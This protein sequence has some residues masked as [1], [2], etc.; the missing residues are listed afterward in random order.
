MQF[1]A[2]RK[3]EGGVGG[4]QQ[5]PAVRLAPDLRRTLE[6]AAAS[7]FGVVV[8]VAAV[9]IVRH[10]V[11]AER[12]LEDFAGRRITV[13]QGVGAVVCDAIQRDL[14]GGGFQRRLA[15]AG[16]RQVVGLRA[17]G[18]GRVGVLAA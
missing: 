14:V 5:L 2:A 15:G 1:Q 4:G 10:A 12:R 18:G 3:R 17:A 9:E 6:L 13:G 16:D 11:A 8:R 7:D